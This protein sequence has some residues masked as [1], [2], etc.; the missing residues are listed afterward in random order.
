MERS[1]PYSQMLSRT[2]YLVDTRRRK[3][4][5]ERAIMDIKPM[6]MSKIMRDPSSALSYCS[7]SMNIVAWVLN[8]DRIPF[9][10]KMR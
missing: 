10:I 1:T 7:W 9:P 6:K 4:V 3:K 2:F 8:R 5:R